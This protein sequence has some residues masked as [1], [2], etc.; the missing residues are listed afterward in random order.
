MAPPAVRLCATPPRLAVPRS[1]S[2]GRPA[3]CVSAL[4]T[5]YVEVA[6]DTGSASLQ[7]GVGLADITPLVRDAVAAAGVRH[8][9]C[10]V[11]SKHTTTAVVVNENEE[12]LFTDVQ[13]FLLRLASP[14]PQSQYKHNDIHLREPPPG[15]TESVETWRAQEPIN[16]HSHLMAMLLGSSESLPIVD[17]M[18]QIGTW[19]SLLLVEL[20]G[21]RKRRVGVHVMGE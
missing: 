16:A 7:R 8:G 14:E 20:D 15:W 1:C 3:P 19:Q 12:R 6:V 13:A 18:L 11:T 9:L 5:R 2:R 21:P 4:T 10:T 17:G